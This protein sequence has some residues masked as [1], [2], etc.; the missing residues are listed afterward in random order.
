LAAKLLTFTAGA[1]GAALTGLKL[2]STG[3]NLGTVT[4]GAVSLGSLS[5]VKRINFKNEIEKIYKS[6]GNWLLRI[7]LNTFTTPITLLIS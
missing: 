5:I 7:N 6:T 1:L 4:E 2:P 3:I